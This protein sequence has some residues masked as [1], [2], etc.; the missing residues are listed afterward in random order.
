[1]AVVVVGGTEYRV[2]DAGVAFP[3]FALTLHIFPSVG[4]DTES[5]CRTL[6]N[7]HCCVP[8]VEAYLSSTL[9]AS[10]MVGGVPFL[11]KRGSLSFDLEELDFLLSLVWSPDVRRRNALSRRH[12][13]AE[14][15]FESGLRG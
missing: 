15:V 3:S 1:M 4:R 6:C 7:L 10:I 9:V 5:S 11:R 8:P 12:W 13:E 2:R 14:V